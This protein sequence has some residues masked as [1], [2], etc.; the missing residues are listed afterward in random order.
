MVYHNGHRLFLQAFVSKRLIKE[1][2]AK[3]LYMKVCNICEADGN[4]DEFLD[5]ISL[6]NK[7]LESLF[8]EIRRGCAEDTGHV[9][10]SLVNKAEDEHSKLA[11]EYQ[12]HEIELIK[13]ALNLI[14]ES[15]NGSVSS[16]DLV[17][18]GMDLTKRIPAQASE[19]L[20]MKLVED[21]WLTEK[22]GKVFFGP[23]TTIEL[24]QYL[25][26]KY[27]EQIGECP[28]CHD[29]VVMGDICENCDVKLHKYCAALSFQKLPANKRKCPKCKT[30][31]T[32]NIIKLSRPNNN[33]N[34]INLE[35][36]VVNH[37]NVPTSSQQPS[38][39]SGKKRAR[40]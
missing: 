3:D 11:T 8:M 5:F 26:N 12:A 23:R 20:I 13:L 2:E 31:W 7:Q 17:N 19:E 38:T 36:T 33:N 21:G 25:R 10:F 9:Y 29:F 37:R 22:D 39:S 4:P 14:I 40:R 1:K 6:I 30:E 15:Q 32:R 27:K 16:L 24:G 18:L 35:E 28:L 34:S